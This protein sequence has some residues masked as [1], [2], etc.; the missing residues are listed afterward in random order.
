MSLQLLISRHLIWLGKYLCVH[1]FSMMWQSG[2]NGTWSRREK[3]LFSCKKD[4]KHVLLSLITEQ[5][6]SSESYL[7]ILFGSKCI[8]RPR[9]QNQMAAGL[10][11]S[12]FTRQRAAHTIRLSKICGT[13]LLYQNVMGPGVNNSHLMTK[14]EVVVSFNEARKQFIW[15][16][17]P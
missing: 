11:K 10:I 1:F 4:T 7:S 3:I 13:L 17:W 8:Y 12:F 9:W 6:S 14:K 2:L 15:R 16:D 5:I